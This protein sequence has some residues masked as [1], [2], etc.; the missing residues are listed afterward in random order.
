M[1]YKDL[2]NKDRKLF[3]Q[4]LLS[5]GFKRCSVLNKILPIS[6]FSTRETADGYQS[7]SNLGKKLLYAKR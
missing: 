3:N 5:F 7:Q 1:N 2:N 4:I 6:E